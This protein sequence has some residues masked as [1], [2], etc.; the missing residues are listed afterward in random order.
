MPA[1]DKRGYLQETAI[2]LCELDGF[3]AV[4]I[5]DIT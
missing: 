2:G 1:A 4:T 3:D 5:D